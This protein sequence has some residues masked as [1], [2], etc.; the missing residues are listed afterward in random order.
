MDDTIK[1]LVQHIMLNG[2]LPKNDNTDKLLNKLSGGAFDV[3]NDNQ[4]NELIK[5]LS[6]KFTVTQMFSVMDAPNLLQTLIFVLFFIR[7]GSELTRKKYK[8]RVNE[9]IAVLQKKLAE[10][11]WTITYFKDLATNLIF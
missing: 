7:F 4:Q 5:Q 11:Q 6:Q 2:I 9:S 1:E 8:R 10:P 3:N